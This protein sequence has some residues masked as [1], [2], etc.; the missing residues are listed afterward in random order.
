MPKDNDVLKDCAEC[1]CLNIRY[2]V[3]WPQRKR[4]LKTKCEKERKF[5]DI[6][7]GMQTMQD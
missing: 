2:I 5:C 3:R 4:K 6:N 1:F 7:K